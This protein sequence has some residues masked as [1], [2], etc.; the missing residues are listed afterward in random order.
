MRALRPAFTH[1]VS[2]AFWSACDSRDLDVLYVS[3]DRHS[4]T[5]WMARSRLGALSD[6]SHA[7]YA[8]LAAWTDEIGDTV[9]E[10]WSAI[11]TDQGAQRELVYR[12]TWPDLADSA[13]ADIHALVASVVES[14]ADRAR[15]L[16]ELY[17]GRPL[18]V[19]FVSRRGGDESR[20]PPDD[21]D[22]E[23]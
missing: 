9:V 8:T 11:A 3:A 14:C 1:A 10:A 13:T 12:S 6:K 22:G 17:F 21:T 5:E 15:K 16:S 2:D 23:G 7:G 20:Q 18:A 4:V 19:E